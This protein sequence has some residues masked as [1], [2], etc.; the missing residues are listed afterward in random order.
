[1]Q[2]FLSA[3]Y[4]TKEQ[5]S[6]VDFLG[7]F[8]DELDSFDLI[9]S[10]KEDPDDYSE[11][12]SNFNDDLE[13][14]EKSDG[15]I[16]VMNDGYEDIY[17]DM[18]YA[19]SLGKPAFG[20]HIGSPIHNSEM[21]PPTGIYKDLNRHFLLNYQEDF[22]NFKE[23]ILKYF[24]KNKVL[25][26]SSDWDLFKEIDSRLQNDFTVIR[27]EI[28]KSLDVDVLDI[29]RLVETGGVSLIIID[30]DSNRFVADY[31]AGRFHSFVEDGEIKIITYCSDNDYML[32]D[33][34][35][36]STSVHC[37]G[38]NELRSILDDVENLPYKR[39]GVEDI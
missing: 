36:V 28:D 34:M 20:V 19:K 13:L 35:K 39:K 18:S 7:S 29:V 23:I 24:N 14:I 32:G 1:M 9:F 5:K 2:L 27:P 6:R 4:D 11:V 31:V 33:K 30:L 3:S 37:R 26:A 8:F 17:W 25:V 10:E 21:L 12:V 15:L 16:G 22:E 38:L